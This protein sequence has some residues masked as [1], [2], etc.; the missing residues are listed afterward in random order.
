MLTTPEPDAEEHRDNATFSALLNA[1][2]R[3]GTIHEMPEPGLLPV[4]LALIDREC[5]AF[6]DDP[7]LAATLKTTG[8]TLVPP[9][10]ADH[11]LM[12]LDSEEA[13]DHLAR[14]TAGSQ[15]YPDQG[16]TVTVPASL[17]TGPQITLSGPGTPG[18]ATI[19]IGNL[20]PAIWRVRAGLCRYPLGIELI[21][22]DGRRLV[23]IPR[24][25]L[26]T[27]G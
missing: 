21:F 1:L 10:L 7:E 11:L 5:R 20:H 19:A 9:E 13:I 4:A 6:A 23:A 17:D 26:V 12:S 14:V 15:L 16:A 18:S 22:V 8:A 3:P 27:E 24:S 2:S 25:T